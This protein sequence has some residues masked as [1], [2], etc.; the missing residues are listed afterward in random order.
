MSVALGSSL[1]A[2]RTQASRRHGA[3]WRIVALGNHQRGIARRRSRAACPLPQ[4][5]CRVVRRSV[6]VR[7]KQERPAGDAEPEHDAEDHE[8]AFHRTGFHTDRRMTRPSRWLHTRLRLAAV[9]TTPTPVFGPRADRV[10]VRCRPRSRNPQHGCREAIRTQAARF[11]SEVRL[12]LR[13]RDPTRPR[14]PVRAATHFRGSLTIVSL[15]RPRGVIFTV[16]DGS[17]DN[18]PARAIMSKGAVAWAQE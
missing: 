10:G 16:D 12:L 3:T 6:L 15:S 2:I 17:R 5:R 11:V 9:V 13:V 1:P 14:G 18:Q 8:D 7:P 4:T